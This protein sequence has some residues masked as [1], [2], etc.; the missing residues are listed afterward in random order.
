MLWHK[1]QWNLLKTK[2]FKIYMGGDLLAHL[3]ILFD[4]VLRIYNID[5]GKSIESITTSIWLF[6]LCFFF[7]SPSYE[8]ATFLYGAIFVTLLGLICTPPLASDFMSNNPSFHGM[9]L[10]YIA[11]YSAMDSI[12]A[13]DP[14]YALASIVFCI[15]LMIFLTAGL[16]G[17]N[18]VG[19]EI[20]RVGLGTLVGFGSGMAF[21]YA[22][23]QTRNTSQDSNEKTA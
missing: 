16:Y 10:G 14:G 19:K 3:K 12:D 18:N 7:L 11:G 4:S 17:L 6:P 2:A 21:S 23:I 20:V 1:K 9:A 13:S 22:N 15:I 8:R 5:I